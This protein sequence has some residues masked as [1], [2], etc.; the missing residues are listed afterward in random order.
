MAEL[1]IDNPENYKSIGHKDGVLKNCQ[2]DNLYWGPI[3]DIRKN[4]F[5]KNNP[6]LMLNKS[7]D[8]LIRKFECYEQAAKYFNMSIG[9]IKKYIRE[10]KVVNQN[11]FW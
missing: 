1:F 11:L 3:E 8:S 5:A 10:K 6:I 7:K 4:N 2:A 9:T